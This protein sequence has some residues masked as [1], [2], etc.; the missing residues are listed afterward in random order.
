MSTGLT[1]LTSVAAV[2][3]ATV[4]GVFY[5]FSTFVMAALRRLP[6]DQGA[7]AMQQIN[8][9]APGPGLMIAMMGT[10][11]TCLAVGI[12]AAVDWQAGRSLVLL[13]AALAYLVGTLGVTVGFNVPLNNA[14][15]VLD[16]AAAGTVQV[17]QDYLQRWTAGNHVRSAAGIAAAAAFVWALLMGG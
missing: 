12:W 1:V 6:A 16:P 2:G 9:T 3:A 15:A 11:G 14:L 8:I 10:A 5:A 7:A 13:G 4:G 17:W